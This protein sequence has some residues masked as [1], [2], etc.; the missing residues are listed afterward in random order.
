MTDEEGIDKE[1]LDAWEVPAPPADL[2]DRVLDALRARAGSAPPPRRRWPWPAA[3]GTVTA[4]A[5]ALLL[6]LRGGGGESA[7]AST[8]TARETVRIGDRAVA[9]AEAGATLSWRI[10]KDG[11]TRVEQPAGDIFYRVERG[12]PFVVATPA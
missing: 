5:A 2:A 10:G 1:L 7:G 3:A 9:V 12:G 8:P 6:I 4:A 11:A